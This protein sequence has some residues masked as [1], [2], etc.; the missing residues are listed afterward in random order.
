MPSAIGVGL[1]KTFA[2]APAAPKI[3][4][5]P[6]PK[7]ADPAL[8]LPPL[9]L[10]PACVVEIF[11]VTISMTDIITVGVNRLTLCAG[12]VF[13]FIRYSCLDFRLMNYAWVVRYMTG[14]LDGALTHPSTGLL[15]HRDV[16]AQCILER[17]LK[18]PWL[19]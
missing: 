1:K 10:S 5:A 9:S 7:I 12:G 11:V 16:V 6:I 13:C 19:L 14:D 17:G 18:S 8:L 3:A 4:V 15:S 2:N